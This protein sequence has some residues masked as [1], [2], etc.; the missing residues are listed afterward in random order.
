V[1]KL[2]RIE[3]DHAIMLN[4]LGSVAIV[5]L[6][7]GHAPI[8]PGTQKCIKR[9][10]HVRNRLITALLVSVTAAAARAELIG[11]SGS[12]TNEFLSDPSTTLIAASSGG[13]TYPIL[14]APDTNETR[15]ASLGALRDQ[16]VGPNMKLWASDVMAVDGEPAQ[17]FVVSDGIQAQRDVLFHKLDLLLLY[18]V[19]S[20]PV[21]FGRDSE[22]K[23][24]E[25]HEYQPGIPVPLGMSYPMRQKRWTFFTEF[26]PI[27]DAAPSTALGWGGGIGIRYYFGR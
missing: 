16:P 1:T 19:H 3:P 10:Y 23:F 4:R 25:H 26:A 20:S 9:K 11:S 13:L 18:E 22:V 5:A 27:L 15:S 2:G 7:M 6:G 14:A 8:H 24:V 17:S 21:Y 12:D